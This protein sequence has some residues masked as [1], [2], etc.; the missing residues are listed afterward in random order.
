ME[1]KKNKLATDK[2]R[3]CWIDISKVLVIWL[4]VLG[5][6]LEKSGLDETIRE[7]IYSFHMPFFFFVSGLLYKR[8]NCSFT[9]FT[10]GNAKSLL[11]PYVF[12]RLLS[13]LILIPY[14]IFRKSDISNYLYEFISGVAD[15]PGGACWFL[16][17]LFCLKE[18]YYWI[19]KLP[20]AYIWLVVILMGG[21]S[22]YI[23]ER[24]FWNLDAAFMAMPF[25]MVGT[26]YKTIIIKYIEKKYSNFVKTLL[27]ISSITLLFYLSNYQGF[28]SLYKTTFGSI[29]TLFYPCAF[30]G[31]GT[32]LLISRQLHSNTF[33]EIYSKGTIVIMGIHGA[34]YPYLMLGYRVFFRPML[35]D[36]LNLTSEILISISIMLL[37]YFPIIWMQKYV[38]FLI[39]NRK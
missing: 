5:H 16:L 18:I 8:K 28:V 30:L 2:S 33:I 7:L 17:C 21:V 38:P 10:V 19:D 29:P 27:L 24:I 12:L 1:L 3:I 36:Y 35:S 39:G 14:F 37:M 13:F 15:S 6:I 22:Y 9:D 20:L 34:V 31:I 23:P 11:I 4:M 26:Q 32:V 25:F